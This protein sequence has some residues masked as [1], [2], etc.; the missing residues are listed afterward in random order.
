MFTMSS[1]MKRAAKREY[2]NQLHLAS[3]QAPLGA[4]YIG[5][6]LVE[7]KVVWETCSHVGLEDN[8]RH[9]ITCKWEELPGKGFI[10][11]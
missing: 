6:T 8:M 2:L 10:R 5:P 3:F 4:R 1:V 11:L 7:W 9:H